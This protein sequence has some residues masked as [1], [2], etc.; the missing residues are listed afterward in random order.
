MKR[1]ADLLF[2]LLLVA[3]LAE[4]LLLNEGTRVWVAH[5]LSMWVVLLRG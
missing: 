2:S 4:W 5:A 3:L 1:H